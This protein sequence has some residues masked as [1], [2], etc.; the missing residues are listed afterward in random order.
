MNV[1]ELARRLKVTPNELREWLPQFGFDIGKKAIKI[2]NNVAG[3]IIEEWPK[4]KEEI[5]KQKQTETS[6]PEAVKMEAST[7]IKVPRYIRVKDFANMAGIPVNKVL[8][9]LMKNS[10]FAS[11]N[12]KIDA[13]TA[14]IVG[15]DLGLEVK[16]EEEDIMGEQTEEEKKLE[17]VLNKQK[18]GN[19]TKRPPVIVV[20]GH[21]DHGKTKLLD[22]IRKVNT[23]EG[24]TGGITQHIGAYQVEKNNRTITFIDT[25]GHEAFTAM[26]SRGAKAADIAVLIVAADDGV[27]PQ[28]IE[29]YKIIQSAGLPF[30]VA[31]NKIDKEGADEGRV[32]QELANQLGIIPEDWGGKTICTPI[33]AIKGTN[34][35]ELLDM[36]LLA[37]DTQEEEMKANPEATAMGTIIE[38]HVN[39]SAGPVATVLVQNGTLKSGDPIVIKGKRYGKV[40]ALRN[41]KGEEI[42]QALPSTPAQILGLRIAPEIGDIMEVS[43]GEKVSKKESK[44]IK[45]RPKEE[46][47]A[48]MPEK[49]GIVTLNLI[50][51]SDVLGSAE[52]VEESLEKIN[53]EE[54]KVKIIDK[55]L[56]NI[57]D[58]DVKKAEASGAQI[59]GFNVKI[60]AQVEHLIKEKEVPVNTFSIIYELIDYVKGEMKK[61]MAPEYE[62]TDLGKLKVLAVFK[63]DKDNQIVGGKVLEGEIKKDSRIE[64]LR[65]KEIVAHGEL[66]RLQS[67]KEDVSTVEENQECGIQ[68]QGKPVIQEG[69][70]LQF[71]KEEEKEKVL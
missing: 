35:Q 67:G 1:T 66:T 54:V 18:D 32:K 11:I 49:E 10:I 25:P 14:S 8:A 41:Y 26:R 29:A 38:S 31:I 23:A 21:V 65:D 19:L 62:R 44:I 58:G 69:D 40:R 57:M 55:G 64:V 20:M 3:K 68:Y 46:N 61:I 47:V 22:T 5:N 34:I 24:E 60:P 33:S 9:E 30:V 53:T 56:G 2:D 13:D 27:K 51:K 28:T 48:T 39:K 7:V 12:E 16:Q 6:K 17:D 70:I 42:K 45:K 37:A 43:E 50:L 71:Y 36:I 63:T 59:I 15:S 52:A 4:I